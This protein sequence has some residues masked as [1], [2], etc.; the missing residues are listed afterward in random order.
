MHRAIHTS[1]AA[2]GLSAGLAGLEHGYFEWLQGNARPEGLFIAS[3][4]PP[5]DPATAWNACEP[6]LTILPSFALTGALAMLLGVATAVWSLF[7]LA[8]PRG[9]AVLALLA[10]GLRLFGG[11]LFP[12]LIALV[13]ALLAWHIRRPL[14]GWAMRVGGLARLYP[15]ALALFLA[16]VLG[17]WVIGYFFNDWLASVMGITVLLILG[18]LLLAP[19]SAF[20]RD[21]ETAT[22]TAG[23]FAG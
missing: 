8:R 19:L 9:G 5:C 4:G 12:P 22:R 21:S 10:V 11:G 3:I 15:A 6:A 17:Q 14:P 16:V 7:F 2:L 23:S 1:A 18:L 20:A 13:A